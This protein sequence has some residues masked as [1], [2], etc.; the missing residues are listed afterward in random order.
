MKALRK[1][2]EIV[3]T[4]NVPDGEIPD[5]VIF[6]DEGFD[7]QVNI[8]T[9]SHWSSY[10]YSNPYSNQKNTNPDTRWN[11]TIDNIDNLWIGRKTPFIYSE[12]FQ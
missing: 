11:T 2:H 1:V 6:S 3:V 9:N 10:P 5:L 7:S 4:H 8:D 12:S